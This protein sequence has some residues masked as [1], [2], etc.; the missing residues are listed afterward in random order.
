MSAQPKRSF[1]LPL[2]RA[3]YPCILHFIVAEG[4]ASIGLLILE[5]RGYGD[6]NSYYNSII[7]LTGI[8]SAFSIIWGLFFY[9]CDKN[10]RK[11][12]IFTEPVLFDNLN[13]FEMVWILF[14]GVGY[15]QLCN[16]VVATFQSFL[17]YEEY[18]ET[19]TQMTNGKS[20][21]FLIAIMGI[22]APICE[23]IVFRWLIYLRLREYLGVVVSIIISALI[24]GIYHG[25][26][27][28]AVY[29]SMLGVV[30]ALFLEM[31]GDLLACMLL[32]IG[33]NVWSLIWSDL[34]TVIIDKMGNLAGT[35]IMGILVALIAVVGSG[36]VYFYNKYRGRQC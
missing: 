2:W 29:A 9:S 26:L 12:E 20:L 27:V 1:W 8:S 32:H 35:M 16:I 36:T 30:F 25:N 33:A 17:N 4:V 5:A 13:V 19:M 11:S 22:V 24:F 31:T 23:E 18:T 21:V 28:Q 6:A 34:A 15:S 7:L 3:I 14:I 10:R